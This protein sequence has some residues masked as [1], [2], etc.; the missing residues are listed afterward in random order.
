VSG[1]PNFTI[2]FVIQGNEFPVEV[3][4]N[5]KIKAAVAKALGQSGSGGNPDEWQVRTEEGKQ[6]D[7][8]KSFEEEGIAGPTKL[9]LSKGPG[10]GG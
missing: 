8:N 6:L 7:I 3:N 10:R 1:N 9:F 2:T 4:P 5:Q